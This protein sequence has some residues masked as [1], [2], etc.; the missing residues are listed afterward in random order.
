MLDPKSSVERW[1]SMDWLQTDHKKTVLQKSIS[2]F[3]RD[4]TFVTT[5][6][7]SR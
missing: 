5:I 7:S 6:T 1:R 4:I 2:E 3:F